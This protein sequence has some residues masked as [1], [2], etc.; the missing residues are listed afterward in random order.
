MLDHYITTNSILPTSTIQRLV[1]K[2]VPEGIR[3]EVWFWLSGG[4]SVAL[5]RNPHYKDLLD[6]DGGFGELID[7]DVSRTFCEEKNWQ[8]KGGAKILKRLLRAYSVRN[9]MVGYCQ[10]MS[11]VAALLIDCCSEE[12]AFCCL[13]ALIEDG[14][15]PP[16]YYTSL[17]GAVVDRL[18]LEELAEQYLKGLCGALENEQRSL[19]EFSF[20]TIPWYLCLFTAT[21]PV[22]VSTRIWDFYLANGMCVIFR[23]SLGILMVAQGPIVSGEDSLNDLRDLIEKSINELGVCDVPDYCTAFNKVTNTVIDVMRESKRKEIEKEEEVDRKFGRKTDNMDRCFLTVK[24]SPEPTEK[25]DDDYFQVE[26]R[27]ADSGGSSGRR[28]ERLMQE[29][30]D[31]MMATFPAGRRRRKG[32]RRLQNM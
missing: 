31:F 24:D 18:V 11:Y 22:D 7:L 26:K 16:D 29:L 2:G 15:M 4:S 9:P 13:C 17:K 20:L 21:L 25:V 28:G 1:S 19:S 32:E 14:P 5:E 27:R 10:G 23:V 30:G 3:E 12:V 6:Q 8:K